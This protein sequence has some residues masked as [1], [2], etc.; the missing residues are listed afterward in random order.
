MLSFI[1][2]NLETLKI[3]PLGSFLSLAMKIVVL[4]L[5]AS[6]VCGLD[7]ESFRWVGLL[8]VPNPWTA[9]KFLFLSAKPPVPAFCL[10]PPVSVSSFHNLW[11]RKDL[12]HYT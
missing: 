2:I 6:K 8:C 3:I 12:K 1:L 9:Q 7:K 4:V 11:P 10:L 5:R